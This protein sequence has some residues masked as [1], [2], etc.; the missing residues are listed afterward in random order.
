VQRRKKT[1]AKA[2]KEKRRSSSSYLSEEHSVPTLEEVS[3]RT[4]NR[5]RSLGSQRFALSPFS[6][7]FGRWLVD[8]RGVVSEFESSPTISV[9]GQFLT[10]RSQILSNVEAGLEERRRKEA[11]LDGITRDLSA[12]RILLEGIEEEYKDKT[13]EVEGRKAVEIKHISNSIDVIKEEMDR[14]AQIKTGIFRRVSEK[15]KAQKMAEATERLNSEQEKLASATQRYSAEKEKLRAEYEKKKQP[16][17]GQMQ[18]QQKEVEN[19]EV[20]GSLETRHAACEALINAV[21]GLLQR[22]KT[23][24]QTSGQQRAEAFK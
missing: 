15:A 24:H 22:E 8:L 1:R 9:D 4:V 13:K 2:A 16:I 17:I 14:I 11:T 5:L 6:E 18:S 7:H 12:S 10:E 3:D 20:D 19:L 23:L 21:D